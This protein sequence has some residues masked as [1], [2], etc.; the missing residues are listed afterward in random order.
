MRTGQTFAY[1]CRILTVS[2]DLV[3]FG[4]VILWEVDVLISWGKKKKQNLMGNVQLHVYSGQL[5]LKLVRKLYGIRWQSVL[6]LSL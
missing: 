2:A 1:P 3:L 5:D 6:P 4:M